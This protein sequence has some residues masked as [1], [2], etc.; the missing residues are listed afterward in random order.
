M[1]GQDEGYNYIGDI[2]SRIKDLEE[3]QKALKDRVLLLGDNLM[4]L[5]EN[6]STKILEIKKDL[7]L[8]KQNMERTVA[9]IET[10][11]KEFSKY[12]KKED[13]DILSRQARMF[14]PLELIRKR[15]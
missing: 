4:E 1:D 12:A 7:E 11:S 8:I 2:N 13:L 5:K 10:A 3:K 9:F 14:Q 15:E 6:H